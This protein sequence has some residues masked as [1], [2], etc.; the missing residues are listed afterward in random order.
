MVIDPGFW[1]GRRVLLT[2]HTGF[3]GSWLS[4]WLQALGADVAGLALPPET[5]PH[6]FGLADVASG[7]TSTFGDVRDLEVLRETLRRHRPEVVLHLAAQA[8]VRRSY[9]APVETYATNVMGTVNLLEAVRGQPG[10]RA[11]LVV[12]SDKCYENRE[13]EW[14]YRENEPMGGRDP[15]SNSKGCAE[16]VTAA[17][18]SS[19]FGRD[20]APAL[21]TARAGNVIGG[22]DWAADRL[23]PDVMRALYARR[24]VEVRN[25]SAV[26]P[27]QHVLEPLGGYLQ[28]AQRLFVDGHAYAQAWNFGP[29]ERDCRPVSAL[30]E[31]LA[32]EWGDGMLW[33]RD[34]ALQPHEATYL[35]L[36]IS[37]AAARLGWRPTWDLEDAVRTIVEWHKA[38]QAGSDMRAVVLGQIEQFTH[39]TE[40]AIQ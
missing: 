9:E 37:K 18:R 1:R 4:L 32:R 31:L 33:K 25:P 7:M 17:Y 20:D 14:G 40:Q 27:W 21:A 19:F 13:W 8:L 22:G 35:K 2:G 28:L 16:L 30:L 5:E 26:R 15:Y 6:L 24:A 34:T 10:V 29:N 23:V 38:H 3:K 11:V 39:R 36:D 12:T